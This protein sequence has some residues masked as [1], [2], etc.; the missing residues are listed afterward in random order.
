MTREMSDNLEGLVPAVYGEE[1]AK[2]LSEHIV[3]SHPSTEYTKQAA[4]AYRQE[5]IR[6]MSPMIYVAG[7]EWGIECDTCYK[8]LLEATGGSVTY[9]Q[10][11]ELAESHVCS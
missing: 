10:I 4:E 1:V 7:D 5:R 2:R 8:T 11:T 9:A 3:F 6:T